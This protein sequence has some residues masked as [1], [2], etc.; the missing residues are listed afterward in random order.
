M[1][2][3][4][5]LLELMVVVI[6]VGILA[7][8]A[9]PQFFKAAEKARASEG[10]NVLG[11]LR[12]AQMRYYAEWENEYASDLNQLDIGFGNLKF[13]NDPSVDKP[14]STSL[15][16]KLGAITRVKKEN[17][18]TLYTLCIRVNGDIECDGQDCP[19][20]IKTGSCN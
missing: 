10:V 1:K 9:M 2:K 8:I 20:G 6:I 13:F 12:S 14:D 18:S 11:A 3:G 19:G 16:G 5:T 4:F 17:N 7:M 15:D